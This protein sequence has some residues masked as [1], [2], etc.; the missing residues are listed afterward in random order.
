MCV[1]RLFLKYCGFSFAANAAQSINTSNKKEKLSQLQQS[2]SQN[3]TI[4]GLSRI[5]HG[6][7]KERL[8]WLLMFL[9]ALLATGY[10]NRL[11]IW[12]YAKGEVRT[13]VRLEHKQSQTW[14]VVT[15]CLRDVIWHHHYCIKKGT[16]M[17]SHLAP[18]CSR[19]YLAPQ[20]EKDMKNDWNLPNIPI[21][22]DT[23]N[24]CSV[25]N[26]N[27]T[28]SHL[29]GD[30]I[31]WTILY[32]DF[33]DHL[34]PDQR[35]L[36]AFIYDGSRARKMKFAYNF[37][38]FSS[39][40]ALVPGSYEMLVGKK[41]INQLG[42]PYDSS[43][44]TKKFVD[45]NM[46]LEYTFANCMD[47]CFSNVA[48]ERCGDVPMISKSYVLDT[49]SSL[50]KNKS[51]LEKCLYFKYLADY[52]NIQKSGRCECSLPCK[53]SEFDVTRIPL[54]QSVFM[55]YTDNKKLRWRL[56]FSFRDD[57]VTVLTEHPLYNAEQLVSQVG[58]IC[59]LFLGLSLLS[60][61]E[62]LI[63]AILTFAKHWA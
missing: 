38:D 26:L 30:N 24:Q 60:I 55:N 27:G 15:F 47:H 19:T 9:T 45:D 16:S 49:E 25:L 35:I 22:T 40:S 18:N 31:G 54:P 21:K 10:M 41:E 28:E 3:F 5:I 2:Y 44:T 12:Q 52:E 20:I 56:R 48:K 23:R 62:L 39:M 46:Q 36:F 1:S 61:S 13:E 32:T 42:P 50:S 17:N 63:H 6:G 57:T 14:P 8:I 43:C 51:E 4:H 34:R 58:G 59:G 11:C 37:H 53:R 29:A 33:N 7:K